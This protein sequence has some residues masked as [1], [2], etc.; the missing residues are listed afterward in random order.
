MGVMRIQ[1]AVIAGGIAFFAASARPSWAE[2]KIQA[3]VS[4]NGRIVFTNLADNTPPIVD[5]TPAAPAA[6]FVDSDVRR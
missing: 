2:E 1:L 4:S 3:L 6:L 5:N